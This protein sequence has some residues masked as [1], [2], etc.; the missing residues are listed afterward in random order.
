MKVAHV[1]HPYGGR[2]ENLAR[3]KRWLAWLR[4]RHP[5]IVFIA[6]W[7]EMCEA[8]PETPELRAYGLRCNCEVIS[9][10]DLFY[11]V[12]GRVSPGMLTELNAAVFEQ[13]LAPDLSGREI[14]DLT[15]LGFEPP[16]EA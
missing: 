2:P 11:M 3:A 13:G 10:C 4:R 1:S 9:R 8:M 6:P 7:I 12:G 14:I 5:E 15:H 16:E